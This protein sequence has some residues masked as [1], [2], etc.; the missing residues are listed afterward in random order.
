MG[1]T[2][3]QEEL[4][5]TTAFVDLRRLGESGAVS[6]N[7]EQGFQHP[8]AQFFRLPDDLKGLA[9]SAEAALLAQRL[10]DWRFERY[11]E[12][13]SGRP[14]QPPAALSRVYYSVRDLLP[15][16]LRRSLQRW[17]LRDWASLSFPRWPVDTSVEDL[18]DRELIG[19]L[20]ANSMA[21]VPFVWFWPQ[22]ASWAGLLT[23]DVETE[24]GLALLP[25]ILDLNEARGI[26]ASV[27]LVA[28]ERYRL[29]SALVAGLRARSVDVNLHGLDHHGNL[30][31]SRE[32]FS[33]QARRLNQY[34]AEYNLAGFRSPCMYRN[35]EWLGE[36]NLSFDMSVP[37]VAH[38]EPQR[39]GCCTVFPY[40]AGR[41]L[42]LPLTTTQDYSLFYLLR[43]H[44][45]RLWEQQIEMITARHGLVSLIAHPDY[46]ETPRA[47]QT[48]GS[49]LD[50]L[51]QRARQERG[52]MATAAQINRWWR[53]RQQMRIVPQSGG[54]RIDGPGADSAVLA[55]ACRQAAGLTFRL[56]SP[57]QDPI[58]FGV[59]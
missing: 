22:G 57:P 37:N 6:A 16:S 36:L 59:N 8:L 28:E 10:D 33:R 56:A 19:L 24:A 27:Q 54:W 17:Y 48:Y 43:D 32:T 9:P 50:L 47:R 26:P 11:P 44:S 4:S 7:W 42:E 41:L 5:A 2:G 38:L 45:I 18:L 53:L 55:F 46:L 14:P 31:A 51:A 3:I 29:T 12:L 20:D 52:W 39:G 58:R 35:L 25:D 1:H 21:E 49:L 23:H 15:V 40:F 34:L 30:F 13:S